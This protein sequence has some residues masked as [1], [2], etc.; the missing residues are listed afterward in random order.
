MLQSRKLTLVR[1]ADNLQNALPFT[2]VISAKIVIQFKWI[3]VIVGAE[4]CPKIQTVSLF[5][6]ILNQPTLVLAVQP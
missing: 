6:V 4:G 3:T 2:Q 1:R 5:V